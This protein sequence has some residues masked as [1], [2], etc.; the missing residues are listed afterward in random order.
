MSINLDVKRFVGI[1]DFAVYKKDSTFYALDMMTKA[2]TSGSSAATV[3]QGAIDTVKARTGKGA[4]YLV[5]DTYDLGT[6]GLNLYS[7]IKLYSEAPSPYFCYKD[8]GCRLNYS[9][10]GYAI[11]MLPQSQQREDV[12]GT[13]TACNCA[14]LEGIGIIGT[15]SGAGAIRMGDGANLGFGNIVKDC[16]VKGFSNGDGILMDI[17]Q[18]NC[19]IENVNMINVKYSL[20]MKGKT[21]SPKAACNVNTISQLWVDGY[22]I[23]GSKGLYTEGECGNNVFLGCCWNVAETAIHLSGTNALYGAYAN[24]FLGGWLEGSTTDI[25]LDSGAWFNRFIGMQAADSPTVTD[26]GT[27]N[28]IDIGAGY[29]TYATGFCLPVQAGGA[30]RQG[31]IYFNPSTNKL[32]IHNGTAWVSVT[33]S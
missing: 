18:I 31:S 3:I 12:E 9:G 17:W 10:T 1:P 14:V 23:S 7:Q 27:G 28:I 25:L 6:T 11:T 29:S 5:P 30:P 4:I 2:L 33:L 13:I 32:Y 8:A 21:S 26:S 15:S 19:R 22:G 16:Y 24:V 20:H